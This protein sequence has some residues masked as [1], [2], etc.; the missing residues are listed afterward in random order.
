MHRGFDS[1]THPV[2]AQLLIPL[3]TNGRIKQNPER[4]IAAL[5]GLNAFGGMY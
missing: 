4:R 1:S 3:K 5:G 2:T